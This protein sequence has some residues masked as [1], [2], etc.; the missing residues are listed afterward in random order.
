MLILNI[1]VSSS[2][3]LPI[4]SYEPE[5]TSLNLKNREKHPLKVIE[6]YQKSHHQIQRIQEPY[7]LSFKLLSSKMLNFLFLP[8]AR[9][10]MHVY[11]F[12]CFSPRDNRIDSV[13]LEC[14]KRAHCSCN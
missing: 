5:K 13:V 10:Q 1:L 8:E 12:V 9:S 2:L 3:I 11:L 4:K 7:C 6:S 14:C